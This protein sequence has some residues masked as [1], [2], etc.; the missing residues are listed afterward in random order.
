LHPITSPL[1]ALGWN[2]QLEQH[3]RE[4]ESEGLVPARV[5]AEHRGMYVL[6]AESGELRADVSGRLRHAASARGELPAVGDWVAVQPLADDGGVVHSLLPRMTKFSRKAAWA[7]TEEQVVASNVDV[8]FLVS[9]LNGDLNLRR[10]ERY[11]ALAWESGATPVVVLNK[12]DLCEDV[13]AAVA[14]VES[15]T[16]GVPILV[17]SGSTGEGVEALR[18]FLQPNRTAVLLGSSGVGKS[19]IVNRLLG[20]DVQRTSELM[21]DGRGRHTTRH[22]QLLLVPGGGLLLDTPGMRELQLWDA[23]EGMDSTFSDIAEL[24]GECRFNDCQHERE[25]GCAVLEAD[26]DG[27]LP[28]GRLQSWRKLQRELRSLEVRQNQRAAAEERRKWSLIT[29]EARGRARLR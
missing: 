3:W 26:R 29:R 6:A 1:E 5:V 2:E 4:H 28:P 14:D 25:P 27:R 23:S 9:A 16:F 8:A 19:T 12:S 17:M 13:D 18:P 24:A 10:L 22:R 15:V 7:A 11:L 21:A 20:E